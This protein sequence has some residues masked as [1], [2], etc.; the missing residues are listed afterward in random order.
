VAAT[1]QPAPDQLDALTHL[2][3]TAVQMAHDVVADPVF[4][5]LTRVFTRLPRA[6]REPTL[7]VLE[8]E[9]EHRVLAAKTAAATG[10]RLVINPHARLY[11]RV[12]QPVVQPE[13]TRD[14]D[15][16]ML[17]TLKA[18]KAMRMLAAS[19]TFPSWRLAAA[20]ACGQLDPEERAAARQIVGEVLALLDA[21][22]H[23]ERDPAR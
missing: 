2:L 19:T 8:R 13:P 23:T 6:D 7:R 10:Y 1:G 16:I 5:R 12:F 3:E 15:N 11:L 17:A 18:L 9:S 22:A 14:H 20:E 4:G 21:S